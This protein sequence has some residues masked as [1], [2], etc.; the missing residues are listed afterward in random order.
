MPAAQWIDTQSTVKIIAKTG[1]FIDN[2]GKSERLDKAARVIH[3]AC[4]VSLEY[5]LRCVAFAVR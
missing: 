4:I 1:F 3:A 2:S 5:N